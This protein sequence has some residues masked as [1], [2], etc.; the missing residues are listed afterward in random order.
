MQHREWPCLIVAFV[1]PVYTRTTNDRFAP[2]AVVRMIRAADSVRTIRGSRLSVS[3]GT[4]RGTLGRCRS[5][6]KAEGN[7]KDP[8]FVRYDSGVATPVR[9]GLSRV[10]VRPDDLLAEAGQRR[11][12]IWQER[13]H[14]QRKAA[15]APR[16]AL[17]DGRARVGAGI[18]QRTGTAKDQ[19]HHGGIAAVLLGRTAHRPCSA[20]RLSVGG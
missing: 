14:W 18:R 16:D 10:R 19:F 20:K 15:R 11:F 13:R 6:Q 3:S 12:E 7:S 4:Y 1:P 5:R 2:E 8:P 9:F 17:L